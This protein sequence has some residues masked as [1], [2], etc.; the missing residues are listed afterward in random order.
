LIIEF[1]GAATFAPSTFRTNY[2][3][4]SS[5]PYD[6]TVDRYQGMN[7]YNSYSYI[8]PI[9]ES[10][11][12]YAG[13]GLSMNWMEIIGDWE[14]TNHDNGSL[15]NGSYKRI[16]DA[17]AYKITKMKFRYADGG[18]IEI[19]KDGDNWNMTRPVADRCDKNQDAG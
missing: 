16:F 8:F 15:D 18:E 7:A 5:K 2:V 1:S 4:G 9:S 13:L 10:F 3:D 19:E 14:S 6:I 17:E 12:A 11:M